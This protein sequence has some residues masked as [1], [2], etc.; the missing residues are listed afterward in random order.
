MEFIERTLKKDVINSIRRNPVT[1]IIGARQ[2]GK[3]TL[4]K[5]VIEEID[6]GLYVDL[7]KPSDRVLLTEA[8]SFF[9]LH[10]GKLICLDEIQLLPNL[11][12]VIRSVV[13]DENFSG[14]FM[15]LGSASPELLR[16]TSESLA[17]RIAYFELSPFS[18]E[19]IQNISSLNNFRLRGGFPKSLLSDHDEEAFEWLEN[20]KITFLE[21]DLRQFGFNLPPDVLHR[22]WTMLAH[23]NGQLLNLS[24]L[25]RSLGVS[26]TTIRNYI[27]VLHHTFML[28]LI[29]PYHGNVKKRLVKSPKVYIR[30]TG[31]LHALLRIS[32]FDELFAHPVYGSSWESTVIENLLLKYKKWDFCFYRTSAGSELDLVLSK[33][34]TMI[35]FEIKTSSS[36]KVSKGFWTAL[37]TLKPDE[38]YVIAPVRQ[39]YPLKNNVWVYPMETFLMKE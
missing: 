33:A 27:D 35:V 24:Q 14:K 21:R 19:E 1:A 11:F 6:N 12:S 23:I 28:R 9:Y 26:Q 5:K 36:P 7:E 37:E 3:S 18:L 15:V 20:F 4:A 30:D 29:P 25:G 16:Q 17:G 13:D 34:N 39:P 2:V 8:E 22:F 32:S 38:A 31:I 10:N